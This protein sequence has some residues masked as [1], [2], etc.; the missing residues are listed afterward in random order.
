MTPDVRGFVKFNLLL[1][2]FWMFLEKVIVA[3]WAMGK[4]RK[5]TMW[6]KWI[7]RDLTPI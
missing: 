6:Y 1:L 3:E 5:K 2:G 4:H 7:H